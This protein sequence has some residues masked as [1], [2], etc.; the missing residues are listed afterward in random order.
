MLKRLSFLNVVAVALAQSSVVLTGLRARRGIGLR[1]KEVSRH[2]GLQ[3]ALYMSIILNMKFK[4]LVLLARLPLVH[5][6][7]IRLPTLLR[8]L[9]LAWTARLAVDGVEAAAS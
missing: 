3:D 2:A 9:Q 1:T 7:D 4:R 8:G 5:A 6:F